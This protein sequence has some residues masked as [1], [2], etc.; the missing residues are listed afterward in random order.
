MVRF[1]SYADD[2]AKDA[3][4]AAHDSAALP[5]PEVLEVGDGSAGP[6]CL[7]V[8]A[9]GVPLD[10]LDESGMR[11]V[12]PALLDALDALR[13]I[14]VPGSQ[15]FGIWRP[16]GIAPYPTWSDALLAVAEDEPG[17]RIHGW[18]RS[19]DRDP[20]AAAAFDDALHELGRLVDQLGAVERRI[21]HGDL[22][23]F[24][25]TWYQAWAV[26]DIRAELEA[27]LA[28]TGELPEDL[29]LRM[30]CYLIHIGLDGLGY[31]AFKERWDDVRAIATRTLGFVNAR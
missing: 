6:F 9:T 13:D 4:M 31:N 20:T 1:G 28:A 7:S 23:S 8:R 19:L 14:D 18:R 10:Q 24:W 2:F 5:I 26:I 11:R 29:D 27:H 12:L 15:G 22:L 3:A 25:W 30:R 21:V 17:N 16:D